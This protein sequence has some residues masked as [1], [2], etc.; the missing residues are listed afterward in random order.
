MHQLS[1]EQVEEDNIQALPESRRS[2]HK[3][4][5]SHVVDMLFGLRKPEEAG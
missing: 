1:T 4:G 5:R 3:V 2:V